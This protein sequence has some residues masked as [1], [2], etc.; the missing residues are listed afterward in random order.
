MSERDTGD[1]K[2]SGPVRGVG[3]PALQAAGLW[4]HLKGLVNYLPSSMTQII[5]KK[6]K[7]TT[8]SVCRGTGREEWR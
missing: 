7:E 2:Y 1:L 4:G 6:L 8:F 3:K 5:P